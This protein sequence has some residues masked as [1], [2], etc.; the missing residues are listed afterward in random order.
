MR[1]PIRSIN[2]EIW[3]IDVEGNQSVAESFEVV[4]MPDVGHF[5]HLE[6]PATFNIKMRKILTE[7][8]PLQ[9]QG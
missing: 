8:L 4:L 5:L 7:F 9:A 1:K 3:P 6:D 2:C